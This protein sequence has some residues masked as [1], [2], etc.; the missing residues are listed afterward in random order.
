M[1]G[2]ILRWKL[3][4]YHLTHWTNF[5]VLPTWRLQQIH[6]NCA[7]LLGRSDVNQSCCRDELSFSEIRIQHTFYEQSDEHF[8]MA[9][10]FFLI[11]W[12][13]CW[14]NSLVGART[15]AWVSLLLRSSFSR[16][17]MEKVAVFPVPDWA[18][19]MTS[20]PVNRVHNAQWKSHNQ[21]SPND[22]IQGLTT[23]RQKREKWQIADVFF[24]HH[25]LQMLWRQPSI[26]QR[27]FQA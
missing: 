9:F 27:C 24:S 8:L 6:Q 18:W 11:E 20:R 12:Q 14:A 17:A 15:S 4:V 21:Y 10:H 16:I 22:T 7:V 5:N 2:P 1:Y 25:S 3:T 13:T 19:A 26:N 23:I